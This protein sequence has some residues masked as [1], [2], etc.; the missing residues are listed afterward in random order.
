M[1]GK[2]IVIEGIEGAG[3][4]SLAIPTI[5]D[6]LI[7]KNINV[8]TTREPG[9]G[10]Y[11]EKI[12]SIFK[13]K[14]KEEKLLPK[15]EVLLVMA[16]RIQLV[17]NIIKP[18]LAQN[19]WVIGDRHQL[20]TYAY[21]GFGRGLDLN[22]LEQIYKF[23]LIN[24]RS[25][26]TIYLDIPPK[27]GL[28]RAQERGEK[29]RIEEEKIEYFQKVRQGYLNYYKKDESIKLVNANQAVESV[30]KDILKIMQSL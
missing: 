21:Q 26:L 11:G 23:S 4:S 15:S 24:F 9:G 2:F 20:S 22:Y 30:K 14:N 17:Q 19:T 7:K 27:E 12:R 6:Y 25:D 16:A 8:I 18:A 13:E 3:K 10:V 29:D 1:Q 5:K 28:K